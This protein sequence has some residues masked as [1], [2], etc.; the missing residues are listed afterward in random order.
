[1][2][3]PGSRRRANAM[4]CPTRARPCRRRGAAGNVRAAGDAADAGGGTG[5]PKG[6]RPGSVRGEPSPGAARSS[7]AAL[8]LGWRT[9]RCRRGAG[10]AP[11]S[12]L[13][14][15][16]RGALVAG[17]ER[18][19]LLLVGVVQVRDHQWPPQQRP[20]REQDRAAGT[21]TEPRRGGRP[22]AG[23]A[24]GSTERLECRRARRCAQRCAASVTS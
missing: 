2:R 15:A 21:G 14:R 20:H 9:E 16:A 13:A 19:E 12:R 8:G 11:E 10:G 7:S 3:G 18:C 22:H 23:G 4:G 5:M 17:L 6:P 1:M 24:S